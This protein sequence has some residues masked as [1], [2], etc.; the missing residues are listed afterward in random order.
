MTRPLVL[1]DLDDTIFQTKG[2]C[3]PH[4]AEDRLVVVATAKTGK[5]SYMTP[6]QKHLLDW[7][8]STADLV[9]VTARSSGAYAGI[10]IRFQAGAVLSN[11]QLILEADGTPDPVWQQRMTAD[12]LPYH[13]TLR[14]LLEE[15]RASCAALGID[16]RSLVVGE[17][18]VLGYVVFKD[19][20]G[21]GDRL[22]EIVFDPDKLQGWTVHHN[23]NNLALIPPVLSKRRAVEYLIA[24]VR[25]TEPDKPVIGFG[26]SVTDIPFL[27]L[28]DMWGMPSR[29]QIVESFAREQAA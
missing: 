15:G 18:G 5:H 3:P 27:Q 6:A 22:P 1:V 24:K 23:G 16:A 13:D 26:D 20:Q 29:S 4:V 7:F 8:M 17:G 25:G 9:P 14:G 19:N 11:G 12:L 21:P 2:K 28:C 10:D